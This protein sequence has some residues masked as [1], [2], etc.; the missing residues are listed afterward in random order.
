M[1]NLHGEGDT[2]QYTVNLAGQ[3]D[4]LINVLDNGA[5]D[6]GV[7]TLIVNGADTVV[8]VS[9]QPNDTF[10]LRRDFV[11]LL[12]GFVSGSG[13]THVERVNYDE[14]INARLIV[15]GLGGNDKFVVDDNS[16]ITTLDGGDGDD[17]FQIGQVFG[18]PR[19]TAAGLAASDT[20]DTTPVI[21]GII[22]DPVTHDVIF[23]PSS[24]DPVSQQLSTKTIAAINAAIAHQAAL[25]LALD[26]VAYVSPGVTHATT[27]FGGD[28]KDT[29][30]VYHNKATLRL[31]GEAGND[32]FIVRA[33][34]TL[35]L[36][37]QGNTEVNGGDGTD[38]I[39][40]AINAPVSIDGGAG[41]DKR[42][43]ARHAVQRRFRRHEP[44]DLRRQPERDVRERRERRAR[45]ARRQRHDLHPRDE[46]GH[47]HHGDRRPGQRHHPGP[48]RR[49]AADRQQRAGPLGRDHPGPVEQ[50][51]AFD[52][53]GVNGVA[54]NVLSAAGESLVK[55]QPIG[56][57][58]LVTEGGTRCVLLHQ[59]GRAEC[60]CARRQSGVPHGVRGSGQ[61]LRPQSCRRG[62]LLVSTDG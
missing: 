27:I 23:D 25:G 21:V 14:N 7:D 10:L 26:G 15:N 53:V 52:D 31:E 1:L 45:Y 28:G 17:T 20:F 16:A 12:N 47:R 57:P 56:A 48:G 5:P 35:D 18:T 38:T 24:F 40:Y 41:F 46:P 30:S 36:S 61:R 33:F 43:R 44:G 55:I 11:A 42:C 9:N 19:T 29:F 4:A 60:R 3:G 49:H 62:G 59:P 54:V 39:N 8:G 32:E 58:L 37:V 2:D 6:D 50:R 13:F 34:V 22:R 51:P